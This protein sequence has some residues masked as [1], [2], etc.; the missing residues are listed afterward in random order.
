[1]G[2]HRVC[3]HST[4]MNVPS[5]NQTY[6]YPRVN[7]VKGGVL[8]SVH[9]TPR[10]CCCCILPLYTGRFTFSID[11]ILS[12]FVLA[13]C[14]VNNPCPRLLSSVANSVAFLLA[15]LFPSSPAVDLPTLFS[16][17]NHDATFSSV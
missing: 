11:S 2:S 6:T 4:W 1:M 5:F 13:P 15:S 16:P 8:S 7:L 17:K 9:T 12:A 3:C 14:V 10:F